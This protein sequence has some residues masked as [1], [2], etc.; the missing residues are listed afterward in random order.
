MNGNGTGRKILLAA[1]SI[2]ALLAL[3]PMDLAP[4][5]YLVTYRADL[6]EPWGPSSED[7]ASFNSDCLRSYYPRRV[8]ASTALREGR[9]PLWD[10]W[11]FCGQPFLA[12]FQSGVLYPVNW[13]LLPFAPER[14]AGLFVWIHLVVAAVGMLLLLRSLGLSPGAALVGGMLFAAGDALAVRTGQSTMLAAASWIP[15]L[16]WSVRRTIH[17]GSIAVLALVFAGTILAGF[18]PILVWA[19]LLAGAW[20]VHQWLEVR[21]ERGTRSILRAAGGFL[22]GA[23]LAA[24]QIVPTAELIGHSDRIRFAWPTLLSSAWH[25]AALLRLLV[26]DWLGSPFDGDDWAHLLSRGDGHYWQSFLS[27]ACYAGAGTLLF[28][29]V[30]FRTALRDR[31]ARFLIIAGAAAAFLLL[32]TPLLRMISLVP[33]LS[34]SRVDRVVHL[35]SIALVVP[36]AFGFDRL[37]GGAGGRRCAVLAAAALAAAAAALLLFGGGIAGRIAGRIAGDA[38]ALA[39]GTSPFAAARASRTLLVLGAALVPFLV[40]PRIRRSLFLL[41]A[42]AAVLVLDPA[43]VARSRHVT[44]GEEGLPRERPEILFLRE[45]AAEGRVVRFEEENLP[46][47]LPGIFGIEDVAGYNAL[48]IKEYRAYLDAFAPGAVKE[49]RINPIEQTWELRSML[50][51]RLAARWVIAP[52]AVSGLLEETR[53]PEE[54]YRLAREGRFRVYED[55]F[56]F[57]RV[58]LAE[59]AVPVGSAEEAM[60]V[61]ARRGR[62]NRVVAVVEGNFPGVE[63]AARAFPA[64][65]GGRPEAA[66][67]GGGEP[68][69]ETAVIVEREPERVVVDC[70]A[71]R[72][73]LLVLADVFY[74]GWR[75]SVDG[76]PARIWRTNRI[77][78]GVAIPAGA[79]RVVFTYRPLSFRVGSALSLLSLAALAA[80][81]FRAIRLRRAR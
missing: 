27:T 72:A 46:P 4:D 70:A 7:G 17:G 66:P 39:A 19:S 63:E 42:A 29:A 38:G 30:G 60:E 6:F 77:L 71:G 68:T 28:A 74:P 23:G 12:N 56:A 45:G 41:V 16:L 40:P 11:S 24:A 5:R 18:P 81:G 76:A 64:G 55:R 53:F 37:R 49:R 48:N 73:R 59:R 79:H 51:A 9:I 20:A 3:F 22:L 8:L 34:G 33:G 58:F 75:V 65:A 44:V 80:L 52:P 67:F 61:L 2:L 43:L 35:F 32:G 14:Q 62:R 26:P 78:R 15:A 57:P 36:A 21:G 1:A 54:R 10:P 31:G 13:A 69:E 47:N 50:L 25:P